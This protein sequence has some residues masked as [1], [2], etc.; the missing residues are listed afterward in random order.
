MQYAKQE[1]DIGQWDDLKQENTW[2][3]TSS[4][5][6]DKLRGATT[7]LVSPSARNGGLI[8]LPAVIQDVLRG[9]Y[10]RPSLAFG[11][12]WRFDWITCGDPRCLAGGYNIKSP[13][14]LRKAPGF[15]LSALQSKL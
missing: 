6:S 12:E 8:G 15:F 3:W 7:G 11:E 10:K 14:L 5:K 1:I 9:G 2:V 13:A 4:R